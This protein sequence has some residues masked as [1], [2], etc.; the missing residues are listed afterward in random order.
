MLW[1]LNTNNRVSV[2]S[3]KIPSTGTIPPPPWG[4]C[5]GIYKKCCEM[6][7]AF[8]RIASSRSQWKILTTR[9]C[10]LRHSNLFI[11]KW[12]LG[13]EP[14][15]WI[16]YIWQTSK[17]FNSTLM[18][19]VMHMTNYKKKPNAYNCNTNTFLILPW[20]YVTWKRYHQVTMHALLL[21]FSWILHKLTWFY[22]KI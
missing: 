6:E 16:Q 3:Y 15:Y 9:L 5:S 13:Y 17:A 7:L 4:V 21:L 22:T 2:M 14:C 11:T 19:A 20:E 8:T 12:P 1:G 10:N 18:F